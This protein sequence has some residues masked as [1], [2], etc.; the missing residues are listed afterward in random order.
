MSADA[1]LRSRLAAGDLDALMLAYDQHAPYVYGVALKVTGTGS[2]AEEITQAVFLALW[3]EPLSFEPA[4][5]S[6][7]GWLV[8]R[9]LHSSALHTRVS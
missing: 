3:E 8:S 9:A 5:G 4:F 7:R 6:L 2:A 1:D